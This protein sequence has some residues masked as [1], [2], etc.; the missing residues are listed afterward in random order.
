MDVDSSI[1]T[2][3]KIINEGNNSYIVRDRNGNTYKL[4]KE[5]IAYLCDNGEYS[6]NLDEVKSRLEGLVS[7]RKFVK[8]S[9]LPLQ[10]LEHN[11]CS[12]GVQIDYVDNCISLEEYL[13]SNRDVDLEQVRSVVIRAV[14]ELVS[15]D[16]VPTEPNFG[17]FLVRNKNDKREIIPIG[18]DNP[19]VKVYSEN[20]DNVFKESDINICYKIIDLSFNRYQ[21]NNN[22]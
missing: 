12:V 4:Y 2:G 17:N 13:L 3:S 20:V 14:D 5:T 7:K 1:L 8:K 19:S 10:V 21:R 15:N 18:L 11:G 9:K 22:K 16:I 6:L